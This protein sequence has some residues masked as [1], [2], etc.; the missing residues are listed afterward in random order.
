MAGTR[1]SMR[2]TG[3]SN[4]SP[5]AASQAVTS[6]SAS[7]QSPRSSRNSRTKTPSLSRRKDLTSNPQIEDDMIEADASD[8]DS[9]AEDKAEAGINSSTESMADGELQSQAIPAEQHGLEPVMDHD[10]Q[11]NS[12]LAARIPGDADDEP[13]ETSLNSPPEIKLEAPA[14]DLANDSDTESE[15]SDEPGPSLGQMEFIVPL[16]F[17]GQARDQ[18]RKTIKYNEELI[19]RFTGRKWSDPPTLLSDAQAFVQT[20]RNITTHIDLTNETTMTQTDIEPADVIEWDRS[21]STK[22]KLLYHLLTAL[23]ETRMHVIIVVQPG[24]ALDI[25]ENFLKGMAIA[26]SRLGVSTTIEASQP[27]K[28]LT[29]SI[30]SADIEDRQRVHG[31]NSALASLPPTSLVLAFDHL[32]DTFKRTMQPVRQVPMHPER[33]APLISFAVIN[34]IDH[35][36]HSIAPMF[37]DPQRLRIVVNCLAKLRK[38]AGRDDIGLPSIEE[39]AVAAAQFVLMARA[40]EDWP[41]PSIGTLNNNDA[42]DLSQG[43]VSMKSNVSSD[44]EKSAKAK[45]AAK[46]SA[47]RPLQD[48]ESREVSKKMRL[49]P[50]LEQDVSDTRISDTTAAPSTE[51]QTHLTERLDAMQ[52]LLKATE[53]Q[54]KISN[55]SSERRIQVLES[56][57]GELQF[58]FEEQTAEKRTLAKE[59]S[60][61]KAQVEIMGRQRESRDITIDKLKEEVRNLKAQLT[62]AHTSLEGSQVPEIVAMEKLRQEKEQA[63]NAKRRAE[64]AAETQES[65]MGYVR[66]QLEEARSRAI[67][68]QEQNQ[69]Y[70]ARITFLERQANGE[71]LRARQL[72]LDE[73]SK[74]E[75]AENLRLKQEVRNLQQLLQR[76]EEELKSRRFGMGTRAG[77]VPRSPRVGPASRAGSPIPDRRIGA[78]KNNLM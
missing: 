48:E 40:E 39:S 33:L 53:E 62:E 16:P 1:R 55:E 28:A 51:T 76:K 42:W 18:Y 70:E 63:E 49:T 38:E 15:D 26:Y 64:R 10:A 66:Q 54:L 30:L 5:S 71:I 37:K 23:R 24:R 52:E 74:S 35:I 8:R 41:L 20:M 44:S 65:T 13:M 78:L 17:A 12:R 11:G 69:K 9:D 29:V 58:R 3:I 72:F 43:L 59:L 45:A 21:V 27:Q 50:Q 32:S 60:E 67:E 75:S 77:S 73:R 47:K 19:E 56:D 46:K 14:D 6:N 68:L 34:S 2:T 57:I 22:F 4:A 31:P 61:S 25:L 7:T 36:D